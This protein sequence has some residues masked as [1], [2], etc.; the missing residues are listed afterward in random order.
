MLS[1]CP[2][3]FLVQI[4]LKEQLPAYT[5]SVTSLYLPYEIHHCYHNNAN[6]LQLQVKQT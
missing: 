1:S 5:L 2:L 3:F 6:Y 4:L